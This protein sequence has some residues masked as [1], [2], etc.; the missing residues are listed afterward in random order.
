MALTPRGTLRIGCGSPPKLESVA[1]RRR[2]TAAQREACKFVQ[3]GQEGR[4]AARSSPTH[5]RRLAWC[6]A[7]AVL[8]LTLI[9]A[10]GT[11]LAPAF[12][13]SL[14]PSRLPPP[15][16][17]PT[18]PQPPPL[19]PPP[20]PPWLPPPSP[21]PPRPPP[22]PCG[23]WCGL[24]FRQPPSLPCGVLLYANPRGPGGEVSARRGACYRHTPQGSSKAVMH[25]YTHLS[26]SF[27]GPPVA[28]SPPP[29]SLNLT[30]RPAASRSSSLRQ[31]GEG[32][33]WP[34]Y[35]A[36]DAVDDEGCASASRR[37]PRGGSRR[38]T[39]VRARCTETHKRRTRSA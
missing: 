18:P 39:W 35:E 14:L 36:G 30:P 21:P 5:A 38:T 10:L 12:L 23:Q 27:F 7:C 11:S 34:Y 37:P 29:L 19:L 9:A 2:R 33:G 32:L 3:L 16:Q 13:R 26:P 6:A 25:V 15:P 17:L 20:L 28:N 31:L 1:R 22:P 24:R 8:Q 4:L